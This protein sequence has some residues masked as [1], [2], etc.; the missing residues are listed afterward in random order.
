MILQIVPYLTAL[1]TEIPFKRINRI[2][3]DVGI[4]AASLTLH[5]LNLDL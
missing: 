2:S 3:L 5:I 1:L 4:R